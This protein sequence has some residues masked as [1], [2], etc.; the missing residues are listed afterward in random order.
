M[1]IT[2]IALLVGASFLSN[3]ANAI[4]F[5]FRVPLS[6]KI[7]SWSSTSPIYHPWADNGVHFD[8]IS[9]SPSADSIAFQV[10]FEQSRICQQGQ[11]RVVDYRQADTFSGEIKIVNS[12]T[13]DRDIDETES[14]RSIG[15]L[16]GW[17]HYD[18]LYTEWVLDLDKGDYDLGEW[19]PEFGQQTTNY[20]QI[21]NFKQDEYRTVTNREIDTFT[22]DIRESGETFEEARTID[23]TLEREIEVIPSDWLNTEVSNY[24]EWLPEMSDQ[25]L[26]FS[27]ERTFEQGQNRVLVGYDNGDGLYS[28]TQNQTLS[29]QSESRDIEV[30]FSEWL[31]TGDPDNCGEWSPEASTV[32]FNESFEQTRVCDQAQSRSRDYASQGVFLLSKSELIS[33]QVTES[34]TFSGSG[35][36]V[37]AST[38][39]TDFTDSGEGYDHADWSPLP[40]N[41]EE[42]YIQTRY[43]Q[44]DQTR[45]KQR[46]EQDRLSGEY[47]DLGEP[48]VQEQTISKEESRNV[49]VS[50]SYASYGEKYEISEWLPAIDEQ[51]ADFDQTQSYKQDRNKVWSYKVGDELI[52]SNSILETDDLSSSREIDVYLPEWVDNG[53]TYSC[54]NWDESS[55]DYFIEQTFE[56]KRNC[57]QDQLRTASYMLDTEILGEYEFEQTVSRE[58]S[59]EINGINKHVLSI[60]S[61]GYLGENPNCVGRFV[62][63][64]GVSTIAQRAWRMVVYNPVTKAEVSNVNYDTYTYISKAYEFESALN[65]IP[66]G[67]LVA[68]ATYDEPTRNAPVFIDELQRYLGAS[69]TSNLEINGGTYYRSAYLIA[70]YKN[71]TKLVEKYGP[72]LGNGVS[73]GPIILD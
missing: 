26:G 50:F 18:P 73:S 17:V 32:G 55:E 52:A 62:Q 31:N 19:T 47:R 61:C 49:D 7:S 14:R 59:D 20:Q 11:S 51:L 63:M 12:V 33:V 38:S 66:D 22:G 10:E 48:V 68:I 67:Y 27:Q 3:S 54:G 9:W 56:R 6:E 35:D 28:V 21:R 72:R 42:D 45:I 58:E 60:A 30:S 40:S 25:I 64:D 8:C 41:Q 57:S 44:Q 43:Y 46:R 2:K 13:E 34:Q 24:S 39:Y 37:V 36:W 71:G 65:A 29:N 53:S 16:R 1:K 69:L 4:D 5:S 15:E 23:Q 70:G